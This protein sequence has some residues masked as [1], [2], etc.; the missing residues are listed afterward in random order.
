MPLGEKMKKKTLLITFLSFFTCLLF[1]DEFLYEVK[2]PRI[3]NKEVEI[4]QTSLSEIQ[5]LSEKEIDGWYG[6]ITE[7]AIKE[8]QKI[9]GVKET[10]KVNSELYKL[11]TNE[12]FSE[13][14]KLDK[15]EKFE[16]FEKVLDGSGYVFEVYCDNTEIKKITKKY[17]RACEPNYT[18]EE[19]YSETIYYF[20]NQYIQKWVQNSDAKW[21]FNLEE[22]EGISL[23]KLVNSL[24]EK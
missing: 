13:I 5:L 7:K 6:S 10:G 12:N 16:L 1:A 15:I 8:L 3:Y 21:N 17:W 20:N 23:K 22:K 18:R 9:I 4:I 24:N 14:I 2:T 11:L 19:Q